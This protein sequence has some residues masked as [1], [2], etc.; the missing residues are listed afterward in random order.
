MKNFFL[1][2]ALRYFAAAQAGPV[3]I[4][5]GAW[6]ILASATWSHAYGTDSG[7]ADAMRTLMRGYAWLGGVDADG[8]GNGATL[9]VVWGKLSIVYYLVDAAV[10][11]VRGARPEGGARWSVWRWAGL[12]GLATLIGMGF[13]LWPSEGSLPGA[14]PVLVL[15]AA[16]SAAA[17]A[18][19]V[20]ARRLAD[21]LA[22]RL[23]PVGPPTP[24]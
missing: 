13:A 19:A 5:N 22:S 9:L 15:L 12:S 10:R 17:A 21:H 18:W 11:A 7:V 2:Q 14:L 4:L 3:V 1:R 20:L 24:P 6:M 23:Q 16:V 8:H